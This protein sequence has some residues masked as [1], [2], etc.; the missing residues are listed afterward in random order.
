MEVDGGR[1][2]SC[3]LSRPIFKASVG[4]YRQAASR[5][6]QLQYCWLELNKLNLLW[7]Q[8]LIIADVSSEMLGSP[9]LW[10]QAGKT[11]TS[12]SPG[13]A[14]GLHSEAVISRQ[15]CPEEDSE[16]EL[17]WQRKDTQEIWLGHQGGGHSEW[18]W[19]SNGVPWK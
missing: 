9:R 1:A 16:P 15:K 17:D 8:M 7:G 2:E 11:C 6:I 3:F 10:V 14:R 18:P 4:V 5:R 19:Q 12:A 13:S